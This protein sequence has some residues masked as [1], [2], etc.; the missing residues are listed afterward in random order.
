MPTFVNF[1][2]ALILSVAIVYT[3]YGLLL[4]AAR[5]VRWTARS[6]CW[7]AG[8]ARDIRAS[9]RDGIAMISYSAGSDRGKRAAAAI[10]RP[11][12][13]DVAIYVGEARQALFAYEQLMFRARSEMRE[14][15]T[16][17]NEII[18]QSQAL[19]ARADAV[20][21]GRPPR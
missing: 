2:Q 14:T 19:M 17:T 9:L 11:L 15:A 13:P 4:L 1:I 10:R 5:C 20:A 7:L 16:R 21:T 18:V 6:I 8:S 12:F 3:T